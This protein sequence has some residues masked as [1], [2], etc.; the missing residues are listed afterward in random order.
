M[1]TRICEEVVA[2]VPSVEYICVMHSD[3]VWDSISGERIMY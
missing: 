2:R 1:I 3:V